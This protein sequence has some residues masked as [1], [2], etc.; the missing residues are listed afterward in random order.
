MARLKP[1]ASLQEAQ[2]AADAVSRE[3]ARTAPDSYE[4]VRAVVVGMRDSITENARSPLLLLFA[5]AG[6][7][8]VIACVNVSSIVLARSASRARDTAICLALGASRG[9]VMRHALVESGVLTAAGAAGGAIIAWWSV[10]AL[11]WLQPAGLP[12]LDAVRLDGPL[13]LFGL[14]L[15]GG[16]GPVMMLDSSAHSPAPSRP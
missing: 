9:D 1:G 13:V 7:V 10:T 3:L 11:T 4:R 8:L 2:A 12:R 15:T 14:I 5:A 16:T 6:L